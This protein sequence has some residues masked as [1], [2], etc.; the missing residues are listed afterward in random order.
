VRAPPTAH[1]LLAAYVCGL[2]VALVWRPHGPHAALLVCVVATWALACLLRPVAALSP[3]APLPPP[4]A[5]PEAGR[6]R[7]RD[8]GPAPIARQFRFASPPGKWIAGVA[9][10]HFRACESRTR[11]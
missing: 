1:L 5:P 2:L 6:R 9:V 3:A 4:D 8:L 11:S 10:S 7:R